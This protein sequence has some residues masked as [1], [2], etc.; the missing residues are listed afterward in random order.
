MAP[1]R[2]SVNE[3]PLASLLAFPTVKKTHPIPA[4]GSWSGSRKSY[5]LSRRAVRTG[6]SRREFMR[7]K[8]FGNSSAKHFNVVVLYSL[9]DCVNAVLPFQPP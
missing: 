2:P 6:A 3:P 5:C 8:N 7:P 4:P 1:R 9:N